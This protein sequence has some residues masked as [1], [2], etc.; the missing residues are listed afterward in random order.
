MNSFERAKHFIAIKASRLVLFAVPLAALTISAVPAKAGTILAAGSNCTVDP[1]SGTC[2]TVQTSATGGNPSANWVTMSGSAV[3]VGSTT[4]FLASGSSNDGVVGAGTI[5][6]SW[7]FSTTGDGGSVNWEVTFQLDIVGSP[8][9]DTFSQSGTAP[10]GTEVMG[11]GSIIIPAQVEVT[12]YN[13]ELQTSSS[14]G[15]YIVDIPGGASLDLNPAAVPEPGSLGLLSA[16]LLAIAA[17]W[18]RRK[19][20]MT[21]CQTKPSTPRASR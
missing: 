7:T 10:I 18:A 4:E 13:I 3:S 9:F 19:Y 15:E 5:P 6:V 14:G 1:G 16:G 21:L 12:G 2:S 20:T 8:F 11:T 17:G